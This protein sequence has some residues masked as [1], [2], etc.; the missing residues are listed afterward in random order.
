MDESKIRYQNEDITVTDK[1]I[2]KLKRKKS[3]FCRKNNI[4]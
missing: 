3:F 2:F 1:F 4:L